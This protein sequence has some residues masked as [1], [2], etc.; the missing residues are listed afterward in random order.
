[1]KAFVTG[2]SGFIGKHLLN[3]LLRKKWRVKVLC[4]KTPLHD[5]GNKVEIIKGDIR[6]LELLKESIEQ[7]EV[8]FHLASALGASL[9]SEKEFFEINALGTKNILQASLVKGAK[10][11][12]HFSSAGVIGYVRDGELADENYP[13]NPEDFYERSKLEAEKIAVE[14]GRKGVNVIIIRPGWVY[15]P[16]DKRTFKLIKAIAE[17]KFFIIGKGETLQTP[18]FIDDLIEG[19]Y[20]C[21]QKGVSGEIYHLAGLEVISVEEMAEIIGGKLGRKILPFKFPVIP[22]EILA[23]SM[24]K[25]YRIF[26]KEAPLTPSKVRFFTKAKP[27]LIEKAKKNLGFYP[28]T[29]FQKGIEKTILWYRKQGWLQK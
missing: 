12:I 19:V 9:I 17:R 26:N 10:R 21:V 27:L 29:T 3:F 11:F 5:F 13:L 6:N 18:I 1:M 2:G 23:W 7:G 28:R 15:G 8:I 14:Y 22:A 4:H 16:G 24:D 25:L 20:L